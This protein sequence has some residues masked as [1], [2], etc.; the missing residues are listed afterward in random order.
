ME[1]HTVDFRNGLLPCHGT[2][3]PGLEMTVERQLGLL[4]EQTLRGVA[5]LDS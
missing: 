2:D 3:G 1:K 5:W 4:S